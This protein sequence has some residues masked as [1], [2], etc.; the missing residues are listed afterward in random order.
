MAEE[1]NCAHVIGVG[2]GVGAGAGVTVFVVLGYTGMFCDL[3][4]LRLL[5]TSVLLPI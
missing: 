5:Y 1:K 3:S 4:M 2:V